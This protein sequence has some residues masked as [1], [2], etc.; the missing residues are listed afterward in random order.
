MRSSYVYRDGKWVNKA[1]GAVDPPR[2]PGQICMPRIDRSDETEPL[3]SAA[4]GKFYT[5]KAAMRES[6]RA[7]NNPRGVEFIE[8]GDDSRYLKGTA[9]ER[10]TGSKADIAEAV[11][12]AQA[13]INR[14]EFDHI[15]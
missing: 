8:V 13:A 12:K 6:Y 9:P 4:D 14:G 2:Y 11:D 5:S 10:D 1:T 3:Q 7:S 15:Q